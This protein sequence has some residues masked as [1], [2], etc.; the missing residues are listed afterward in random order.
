MCSNQNGILVTINKNDI[1]VL[2]AEF[3]TWVT[4]AEYHSLERSGVIMPG[5]HSKT[6][7][8]R[9]FDGKKRR[10]VRLDRLKIDALLD[11]R[12]FTAA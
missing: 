4:N 6:V 3:H 9:I 1:L 5:K 11:K 2:N 7:E 12:S 8:K 10:Y